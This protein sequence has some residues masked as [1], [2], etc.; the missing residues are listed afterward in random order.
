MGEAVEQVGPNR[1]DLRQD[2]DHWRQQATNLLTHQPANQNP[3]PRQETPAKRRAWPVLVALLAFA[4][5]MA[6]GLYAMRY[7]GLF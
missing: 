4:G 7:Y 1:D 2:R 6:G 3:L 5:G